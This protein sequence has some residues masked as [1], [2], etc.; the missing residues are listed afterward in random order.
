MKT[1]NIVVSV[2]LV[3][4]I[5]I[6]LILQIWQPHEAIPAQGSTKIQTMERLRL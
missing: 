2:V 6:L 4:L 3:F 5:A 1:K